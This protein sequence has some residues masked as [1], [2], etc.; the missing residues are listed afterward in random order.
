MV[1]LLIG[2][3]GCQ[4]GKTNNSR[5]YNSRKTINVVD[6]IGFGLGEGGDFHHKC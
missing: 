5:L 1:A 3:I 2:W 6:T 4:F